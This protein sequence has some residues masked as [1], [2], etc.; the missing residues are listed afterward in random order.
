MV[1]RRFDSEILI[2][3]GRIHGTARKTGET[4]D[5]PEVHVWA[6]RGGRI[7]DFAAYPDVP[8]VQAAATA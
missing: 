7:T 6:I 2:Q 8:A 5:A 1:A 3:T 4:F